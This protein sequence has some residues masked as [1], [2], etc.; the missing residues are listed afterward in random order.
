MI[1]K[2]VTKEFFFTIFTILFQSQRVALIFLPWPG[3]FFKE[4]LLPTFLTFETNLEMEDFVTFI[5]LATFDTERPESGPQ[6]AAAQWL[7][8]DQTWS[9]VKS[10]TKIMKFSKFGKQK[11]L[12]HKHNLHESEKLK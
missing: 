4:H 12:M 11:N 10:E 8:H 1:F 5:G 2:A 3:K 6:T 9:C 7:E